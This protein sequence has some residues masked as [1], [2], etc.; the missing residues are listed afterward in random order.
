MMEEMEK[1]GLVSGMDQNGFREVL[2]EES[3]I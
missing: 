1:R 2:S 3:G